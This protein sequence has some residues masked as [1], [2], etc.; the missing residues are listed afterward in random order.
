MVERQSDS[1]EWESSIQTIDQL[2]DRNRC[3]TSG[4]GGLLPGC[5]HRGQVGPRRD[6]LPHKLP[7]TTGRFTCREMFY[8]KQD[9]SSGSTTDGQHFSS[10]IYQQDGGTHSPLLSYLAKNL[11]DWCL[12]C[13]L[14]VR[15]QYIPG[16][17]NVVAD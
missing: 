16:I 5:L 1:M 12:S 11:W 15:A 4:L 7:G 6:L 8:Q 3:I 10:N 17:Q 2:S 14:L 13:N 9:K